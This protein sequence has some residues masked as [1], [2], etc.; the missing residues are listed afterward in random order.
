VNFL[1][2]L[3][4]LFFEHIRRFA[5][6]NGTQT[7]TGVFHL[8]FPFSRAKVATSL[9][10]VTRLPPEDSNVRHQA[11]PDLG[12]CRKLTIRL[13]QTV[14]AS[15]VKYDVFLSIARGGM[16]PALLLAQA[17]DHGVT[18][19]AHFKRYETGQTDSEALPRILSFPN[20]SDLANRRV[21]LIDEVWD[22]GDSLIQADQRL[23][24]LEVQLVDIAVL[25]FKPGRNRYPLRR[26]K[27]LVEET[28]D[29]IVS[30]G[31]VR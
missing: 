11:L 22:R 1:R 27:Y 19:T 20:Q 15:G 7:R 17:V 24:T 5:V 2:P 8:T 13:A 18:L 9:P 26:P 30:P 4:G 12:R 23:Q 16:F 25:H 21:L 31:A 3:T 14:R 10:F 6:S 29:W 28:E